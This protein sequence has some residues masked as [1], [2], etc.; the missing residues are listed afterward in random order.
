M[1]LSQLEHLV[2]IV[3][4]GSLRAAA[5]HMGVPQPLLTRSIRLLERELGASLFSREAKGM[6]L[7]H[8]GRLFH[9]RASAIVH[10]SHRA[11][12]EVA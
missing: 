7:T 3:E 8:V 4:H 5:R 12:Q 10:E 1:K 9:V 11:R 6:A 2:S